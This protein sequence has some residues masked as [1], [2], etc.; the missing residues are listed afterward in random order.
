MRWLAMLLFA[1][2]ASTPHPRFANAPPVLQVDDRHDV[3]TKPSERPF[4]RA[5]LHFDSY[6]LQLVRAFKLTRD[7][8]ALG[9]NSF[10]DV[11]DSTWFTNRIGKRAATLDEIRRGPGLDSPEGH[12]PWTIMR[13]KAGGTAPGFVI[14][15]NRGSQFLLKFDRPGFPELETAVDAIVA[16]LLWLSGYNVPSDHVVYFTPAD[17]LLAPDAYIKVGDKKKKLDKKQV[18]ETFATLQESPGKLRGI[19]SILVDGKPLGGAPRVGVRADDPNDRIPH[20]MRRDIRGQ[21][22][23]IAWLAHADVKED[24][25][26]D[27]W[28]TDPANKDIH[29]VVHYLLDFGEAM[30]ADIAVN[31]G[32]SL[33]Y[34]YSID[35]KAILKWAVT[36][37]L[38]PTPWKA[39]A[40]P[41]ILGIGVYSNEGYNPGAWRT[42]TP[43]HLPVIWADRFDQFWGS[44]VIIKF[45]REQIEAAVDSG[46]FTDP[47]AKPYLVDTLVARQRT[48]ARYWFSRVNPIDDFAIE[49]GRLCFTD[50]ALRHQ[51][52]TVATQ[53]TARSSDAAGRS[54]KAPTSVAT[55]PAGRACM[56]LDL[57]DGQ[58]RYTIVHIDSSR[59][60]PGTQVHVS[61]DPATGQPHVIGIYRL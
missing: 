41:G 35:F 49:S 15:D 8:R 20:E 28:Q 21:A 9:V 44:K 36:L 31:K 11:P 52:E 5:S 6:Y 55:D 1:A 59:G 50:L 32:H 39:R 10:D 16:R 45:T 58:D 24:N 33:G 4:L 46:R 3:K 40:A 54:M 42:S 60:M 57:A 48:T 47:R 34:E 38:A 23:V 37:G 53:F 26:I 17:L 56:S 30:G 43:A 61:V 22:A 13:L 51:L 18:D 12:F 27:V 14:K 19:A 29:Y 25:T 2:C 7:R